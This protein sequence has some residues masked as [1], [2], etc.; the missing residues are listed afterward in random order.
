MS[1]I[2]LEGYDEH[3]PVPRALIST[4]IGCGCDDYHAC[5]DKDKDQPCHWL[6]VDRNELIGV[7]SA[8]SSHLSRWD[9]E[10]EQRTA[11]NGSWRDL[12][13]GEEKRIGDRFLY[14]DEWKIIED[15]HLEIQSMRTMSIAS[16]PTQRKVESIEQITMTLSHLKSEKQAM[17]NLLKELLEARPGSTYFHKWEIRIE[18]ILSQLTD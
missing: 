3:I 18:D 6:R 14:D 7:C 15:V 8:C 2:D 10:I 16:R 9:K 1:S 13:L 17:V 4:C 12:K 11:M 5:I